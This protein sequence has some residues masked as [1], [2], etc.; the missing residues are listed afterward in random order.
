MKKTGILSIL[1]SVLIAC[2][3]TNE[4][5]VVV[6]SASEKVN[7]ID[8]RE[9][10]M[11]EVDKYTAL[12]FQ[13]SIKLN[14]ENANKLLSAYEQ[15]IIH[16]SFQSDSKEIMF[17]AG[18]LAKALNRPHGAIK[19]FN[20]LLERDPDHEKAPIALFYKAMIIGD[21]LHEDDLAIKTYKEFID[22]YPNHP[23]VESAKQSIALQGKSLDDIVKEFEKKN[24]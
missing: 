12:V 1:I 15:Y 22:T 18:E 6:E 11:A 8:T 5:D 19:Y 20:Q 9:E 21:V 2:S 17:K 23:F 10:R 13:D 24:S 14:I 3:T 4:D 16:H 7:I